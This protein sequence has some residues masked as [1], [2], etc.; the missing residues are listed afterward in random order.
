MTIL[1]FLFI[2]LGALG[3]IAAVQW[4]QGRWLDSGRWIVR[5]SSFHF[6]AGIPTAGIFVMALGLSFIWAPGTILAFLS[7]GAYLWVLFSSA[8]RTEAEAAPMGRPEARRDEP[9]RPA[10]APGEQREAQPPQ[11]RAG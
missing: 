5:N 1:G 4:R 9:K 2:A 3:P 10:A 8:S 11:R 7:A 6:L